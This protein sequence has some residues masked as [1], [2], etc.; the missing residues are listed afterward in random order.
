[1]VF[2][3]SNYYPTS[4]FIKCLDNEFEFE[5]NYVTAVVGK[6]TLW[7]MRFNWYHCVWSLLHAS[8]QDWFMNWQALLRSSTVWAWCMRGKFP[9]HTPLAEE[10][11]SIEQKLPR[12]Q[13]L[14]TFTPSLE[15]PVAPT[16]PESPSFSAKMVLSCV[17]FHPEA[18]TILAVSNFLH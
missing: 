11:C 13:W 3:Q 17:Y 4:F 5:L 16:W 18:F 12:R 9:E 7:T 8:P 6:N 14:A 1:M 10:C 15:I 2:H